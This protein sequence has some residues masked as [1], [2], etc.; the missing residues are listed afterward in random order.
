LSQENHDYNVQLKDAVVA[1][2]QHLIPSCAACFPPAL[3][4]L[5]EEL[6]NIW[7]LDDYE[8]SLEELEEVLIVGGG[9]G[10]RGGGA[11]GNNRTGLYLCYMIMIKR[12]CVHDMCSLSDAAQHAPEY[13][14][15]IW[16]C[17]AMPSR[18]LTLAP[19]RLSRLWT[20]SVM[21]SRQAG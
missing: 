19:R 3:A 8:S 16:P 9:E 1:I 14:Q 13:P 11:G 2:Q 5:V 21:A 6:L 15:Y 4:Q 7:S 20:A 18:L 10:G 17:V 12:G